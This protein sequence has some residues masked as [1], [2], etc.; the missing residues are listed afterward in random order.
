MPASAR[1]AYR[2]DADRETRQGRG[3]KMKQRDSH[4]D[5]AYRQSAEGRVQGPFR[6]AI[7]L[8]LTLILDFVLL[9]E[10]VLKITTLDTGTAAKI[11]FGS[12]SR[13]APTVLADA[14]EQKAHRIWAAP[15]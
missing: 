7:D 1:A 4:S 9:D 15:V 8:L 5:D 10:P 2:A 13:P 6:I 11:N 14:G 3:S 12:A